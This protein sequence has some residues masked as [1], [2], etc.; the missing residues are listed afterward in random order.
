MVGTVSLALL[1]GLFTLIFLWLVGVPYPFALAF[2][3]AVL[4]IAPLVGTAL[5]AIVV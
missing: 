1:R 4:D 3:A 2:I 5:A